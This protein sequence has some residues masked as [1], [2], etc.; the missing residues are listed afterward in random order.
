MICAWTAGEEGLKEGSAPGAETFPLPKLMMPWEPLVFLVDPQLAPYYAIVG[1]SFAAMFTS[2]TLLPIYLAKPPYSLSAGLIGVTY[3]AVG[4]SMLV[5]SIVGGALSDYSLARYGARSLDGRMTLVLWGMWLIP[6]GTVGFGFALHQ[7][8]SL[9][10]VLAAQSVLGF[11]QAML[12]P[13]TLG[14]LS[15]ARPDRA[16]A[17]GSVLLFLCFCAS[18]VCISISV[19]ITDAIG[20]HYFFVIA[21][22]AVA[23]CALWATVCNILRVATHVPAAVVPAFSPCP[24][25]VVISRDDEFAQTRAPVSV[26][27][28]TWMPEHIWSWSPPVLPASPV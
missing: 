23:M 16:G 13:S 4:I 12:M 11:G 8:A 15:S 19:I 27:G 10:G 22:G 14:Y 6:V 17:A 25:P 1:S 2:L 18:A 7:G 28:A 24:D 3:L 21:A 20:V 9:A 5:A 26:S